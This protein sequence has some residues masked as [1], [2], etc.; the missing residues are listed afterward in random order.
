MRCSKQLCAA[1]VYGCAQVKSAWSENKTEPLVAQC[2]TKL[3]HFFY[4]YITK[5]QIFLLFVEKKSKNNAE[6]AG[7]L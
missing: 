7:L 5:R 4:I 1:L 2:D 3:F 6:S